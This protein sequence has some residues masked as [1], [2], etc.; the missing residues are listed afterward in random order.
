M[1]QLSHLFER[2][3]SELHYT[4]GSSGDESLDCGMEDP[5]Y[6]WYAGIC[7]STEFPDVRDILDWKKFDIFDYS[8]RSVPGTLFQELF[9]SIFDIHFRSIVPLQISR[10]KLFHA[11]GNA[12]HCYEHPYNE[13]NSNSFHNALHAVDTLVN[14]GSLLYNINR[15]S[16]SIDYFSPELLYALGIAALFHDFRHP[17]VQADFL[18]HTRESIALRYE[19][20]SLLERMH[21]AETFEFLAKFDCFPKDD[22]QYS[23][24]RHACM[25]S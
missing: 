5:R 22:T 24:F 3:G 8:V 1:D 2:K 4:K 11:I 21:C 19:G 10:Q 18:K 9:G 12:Q 20:K 13:G 7:H 17:G 6:I 14:A 23:K 16:I 15:N 25:C